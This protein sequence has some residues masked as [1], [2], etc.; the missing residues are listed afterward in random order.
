VNQR[1]L[2]Q[3]TIQPN[4]REEGPMKGIPG[5]TLIRTTRILALP[6]MNPSISAWL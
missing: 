2:W 5:S 4:T 6:A 1:L 3:G